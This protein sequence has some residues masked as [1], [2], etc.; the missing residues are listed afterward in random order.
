MKLLTD[1]DCLAPPLTGIGHYTRELTE[2]LINQHAI[3]DITAMF[4]GRFIQHEEVCRL[5]NTQAVTTDGKKSGL[6]TRIKPFVRQ[7]PFARRAWQRT[8]AHRFQ[9]L[10]QTHGHDV[11][12]EPNFILKPSRCPSV[13]T[14]YDLSPLA[15]PELHPKSRV[16]QLKRALATSV[17]QA[18]RVITI[19]QF[20]AQALDEHLGVPKDKIRLVPPAAADAFH[21]YDHQKLQVVRQ[22]YSL[23]ERFILSVGTLEPRKNLSRLLSAYERL[24]A[25]LRQQWP[26]VC[27][28]AKGWNDAT[29]SSDIHRLE[30]Q[31]EL[32]RLGYVPQRDL[33]VLTAAAGLMAYMSF[34]EGFGMPVVES[35]ACGVPVLTS[36]GTAMEEVAGHCAFYADP[37]DVDD[38]AHSLQMAL[39]DEPKRQQLS[40]AG[41]AQA[42]RYDWKSSASTLYQTLDEL[43]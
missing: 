28:G 24:P 17:H 22:R 31:G 14:I 32:I 39:H 40:R 38:I 6:L 13:V 1:L 37:L 26:L 19:S 3:S 41:P 10:S 15:H 9:T 20:T 34:Y 4:H 12:W 2:Q 23:P 27:V 11:Y 8:K 35:L 36:R 29:L 33:P 16:V 5:L 42:D 25:A 21:P 43:R 18:D 30:A 7:L